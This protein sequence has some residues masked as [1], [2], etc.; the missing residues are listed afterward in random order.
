[1]PVS[2]I[3]C[4]VLALI[5]CCLPGVGLFVAMGAGSAG[6]GLGWIGFARR[7]A[8]GASRLLGAAAMA[9]AGLALILAAVRYTVTLMALS[10]LVSRLAA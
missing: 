3:A 6:I 4:A 5:A 1:V 7:R 10:Q 8:P 2:A 9:V